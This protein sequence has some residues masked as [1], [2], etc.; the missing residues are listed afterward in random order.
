MP[1]GLGNGKSGYKDLER[2]P[3]SARDE[4]DEDNGMP[5][6]PYSDIPLSEREDADLNGDDNGARRNGTNGS[7]SR[8]QAKG[9]AIHDDTPY[10]DADDD[11]YEEADY[12]DGNKP[13][14]YYRGGLLCAYLKYCL[15][16][17]CCT[18]C[19]DPKTKRLRRK[20][21]GGGSRNYGPDDSKCCRRTRRVV[22]GLFYL[23]LFVV[24]LLCASAIGYIVAQDGSPF[25]PD[26][27]SENDDNVTTGKLFGNKKKSNELPAPPSN[28]H[29]I[30]TDWITAAGREAC[31]E[32]CDVAACCALP[33][34]DKDNCWVDDPA[35]CA[36]YRAACMALELHDADNN[37]GSDGASSSG[38]AANA[39]PSSDKPLLEAAVSLAKP[40]QGHLHQ[41]CSSASLNTPW[42]FDLCEDACRP[43]R[44]CDPETYSCTIDPPED[45]EWCSLYE[46]PCKG[47]AE[48]WRGN[49]HA[50]AD[51][52]GGGTATPPQGETI[53][54]KVIRTC[55]SA[56]LNP[57]NEC[58]EACKPGA[59]CYVS[60]T[61][62]PIQQLFAEFYGPKDT[63]FQI[64]FESCAAQLGF[65]QQF[66]SCEH[67]NHLI[68]TSGWHSDDVTY[69]LDIG[70]VCKADHVAQF[71][72]LE[73]S[74][75]CQPAHCCFSGEYSC[76]EV[77]LG[78]LDCK[79]YAPCGVL[80]PGYKST[81]ELF[82]MAEHIDVVCSEENI[83]TMKG[84][85]ECQG[86]CKDRLCCFDDGKYGC[87]N[88]PSQNCL[89]YAGCDTLVSTPITYVDNE[90]NTDP[91]IGNVKVDVFSTELEGVCS[92]N[93]LK[94]LD[95][96][97]QCHN[98]CQTHLCCFTD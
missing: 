64:H 8:K 18:C 59:C 11:D 36:T 49:G 47:V 20:M 86:L 13:T 91:I 27:L 54:N 46:I 69:E 25:A 77:N 32:K 83:N 39:G 66:G 17:K 90:K 79:D 94:T 38:S 7:S 63:P 60:D 19:E 6:P 55:N 62:P 31:K 41:I 84:R 92:V 97:Q 87:A 89:A 30:C 93:S 15:A 42:G 3:L 40:D 74:N 10:A 29:D 45:E 82:Q 72:A 26:P 33:A 61:F 51:S 75:V 21:S 35:D 34:Y 58:I 85:S 9:I 65:C 37:D 43:S 14:R 68:D 24:I 57:P 2:A 23:L 76:E 98:K 22:M 96:I 95:G 53:T 78:Q 16:C 81:K 5:L 67:L 70:A 48:S 44:C 50:V 73:C 52:A 56:N 71:G 12:F 4:D 1:F 28:L 88:D 80:Y